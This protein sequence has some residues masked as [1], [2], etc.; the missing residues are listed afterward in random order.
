MGD[1]FF[2][3]KAHPAATS[4]AAAAAANAHRNAGPDFEAWGFAIAL[5][6]QSK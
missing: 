1:D 2:A 6:A 5:N 3:A 4:A